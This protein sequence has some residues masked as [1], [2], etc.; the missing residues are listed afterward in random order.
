[1]RPS[2]PSKAFWPL[3]AC[4]AGLA[5][6]GRL[7][8]LLKADKFLDADHAVWGLMARHIAQGPPW[9]IYMWGQGYMGAGEAYYLAPWFAWLG[10]TP[11]VM[12]WALSGLFL[13]GL[14]L[15]AGLARR[16]A[17]PGLA[18]GALLLAALAPPFFIRVTLLC[19][20][21]YVSVGLWGMLLWLAW[22]G[23]FL[24][25]G[26]PRVEPWRLGLIA[27]AAALGWWTWAM[28]WFFALPCLLFHAVSLAP[29]LKPWPGWAG[30][31]PRQR[32]QL[33][34]LGALALG[35]AIK[36]G[37]DLA[38]YLGP[39]RA[40]GGYVPP[41]Y[42]VG[43]GRVAANLSLLWQRM[44][45]EAFG[46]HPP[47]D[48]AWPGRLIFLAGLAASLV[49]VAS[50]WRGW[51]RGGLELWSRA[52][53]LAGACA[54]A[55]LGLLAALLFTSATVDRFSARYLA[56]SIWWWPFLLAWGAAALG[57]R[58]RWAGG[59]AWGGLAGLLL[60]GA[61]A[62]CLHPAAWRST[63]WREHYGPLIKALEQEGVRQGW[64]DYGV[65]YKLSFLSGERYV[66]SPRAG[67]PDP[68][69][70]CPPHA[71]L[72]S[73]APRR[74]FLFRPGVDDAARAKVRA[75]LT[76]QGEPWREEAVGPFRVIWAGPPSSG[77]AAKAAPRSAPERAGAA[78]PG[79]P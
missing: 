70:R 59:L 29:N 55:W 39:L 58:A 72:V 6:Y 60:A 13:A 15:A 35:L 1:M 48:A 27:L 3:A 9:P 47:L 2:R 8:W 30:L 40:W 52:N 57:R 28:F 75:E 65:A 36:L 66:F 12:A 44:I 51:R 14:L 77:G 16:L 20:G 61:L 63:T 53:W 21:G 45:P 22:S 5:L 50:A 26:A 74:A 4:L 78:P 73:R 17:G 18:L 46:L 79:R 24:G 42:P 34:G 68:Q 76:A 56:V 10:A 71:E 54:L 11:T 69:V 62:V 33:L 23:A 31:W 19:Y 49:V 64:A 7:P 43:P 37:V 38:F 32:T 41:M 25:P 67:Y